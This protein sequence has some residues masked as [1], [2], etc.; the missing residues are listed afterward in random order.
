MTSERSDSPSD[1]KGVVGILRCTVCG[2]EH[3][4]GAIGNKLRD[5]WP[6]CHGYTMRWVT[7]RQ[8]AEE[9]STR[10]DA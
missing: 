4:L 6:K 9:S 1:A 7:A 3:P 10:E 5:G 8:L 2:T